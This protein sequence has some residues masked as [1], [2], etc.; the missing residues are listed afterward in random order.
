M[1]QLRK[2][3]ELKIKL[4]LDSSKL[5][6]EKY[7]AEIDL[8]LKRERLEIEKSKQQGS[9]ETVDD[10]FLEALKASAADVWAEEQPEPSSGPGQ[11]PDD[12]DGVESD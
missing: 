11:D 9:P 6:F 2:L 5:E 12:Q 8:Q 4:G 1:D 7:K 3:I 10:G